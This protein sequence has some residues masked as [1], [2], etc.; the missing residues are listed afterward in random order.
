MRHHA[1][2]QARRATIQYFHNGSLTTSAPVDAYDADQHP[3]AVQHLAQ[4]GNDL[5]VGLREMEAVEAV[6]AALVAAGTGIREVRRTTRS[7]EDVYLELMQKE[8]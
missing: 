6:V 5:T 2:N 8:G 4:E 1:T 3:V 7:L